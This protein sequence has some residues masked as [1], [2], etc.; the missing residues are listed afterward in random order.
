MTVR[1]PSLACALIK[2]AR[3]ELTEA[4]EMVNG[5]L[6][7]MGKGRAVSSTIRTRP[8]C[9]LGSASASLR[10]YRTL[11]RW[12]LALCV[13]CWA[14][15]SAGRSVATVEVEPSGAQ[16]APADED[17]IAVAA[18]QPKCDPESAEMF[19]EQGKEL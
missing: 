13:G 4:R 15:P 1:A 2:A 16:P 5:S 9:R 10:G 17:P 6:R 14:A 8:S 11:L 19:F 12:W 3:V 7:G 18:P